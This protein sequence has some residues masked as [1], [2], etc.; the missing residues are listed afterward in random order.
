VGQ[1]KE[2]GH[3]DQGRVQGH[4]QGQSQGHENVEEE[5]LPNQDVGTKPFKR[6]FTVFLNISYN[7]TLQG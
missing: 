4:V 1:E 7:Y 3:Q 5:D 6:I 2:S